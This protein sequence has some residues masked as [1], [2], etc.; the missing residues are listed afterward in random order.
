MDHPNEMFEYYSIPAY[1]NLGAPAR[2]M[3]KNI[4]SIKF[5]VETGTV[6]FGKL[7]PRVLKVWMVESKSPLR[8]IATTEFLPVLANELAEPQFLYYLLQASFVVEE[9]TRMVSGS[10]PSRERVDPNAFYQITI[11][12]PPLA[13]QR[14]IA[15]ILHAVQDARE[16]RRRELALERERKAVLMEDLFAY[17]VRR[18]VRK[19][20]AL[21]QMPEN[22]QVRRLGEI[23]EVAYGLTVNQTRRQSQH[24]VPYLTVANVTR[25]R[26]RL[27]AVKQIG[28]VDGDTERF[29]LQCGDVLLVEGNGNPQLLGSAAIWNDEIPLALHQNHLIRVRPDSGIILPRW[30]MYYLNSDFG[31][32]QLLGKSTT[33]SGLHSINSQIVSNLAIPCPSLDEQ[34]DIANVLTICDQKIGAL[35]AEAKIYDELFRALLEELMTDRISTAEIANARLNEADI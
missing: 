31:R 21:G 2:E 16:A 28:T 19:E 4:L 3:G 22:W 11:P 29:R 24:L 13:E 1:Q 26:L 10:T 34:R 12:L 15:A 5:A 14:V 18:E 7:N 6:L 23:G 20:T 35:E 17:G 9:A 8:K 27:D 30:I 33:S 32:I 25:G